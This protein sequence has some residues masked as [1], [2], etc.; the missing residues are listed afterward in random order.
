LP[1]R[2][3][4]PLG[5]LLLLLVPRFP[6]LKA[7]LP[8]LDGAGTA[9]AVPNK[10]CEPA[11]LEPELSDPNIEGLAAAEP[12]AA[13]VVPNGEAAAPPTFPKRPPPELGVELFWLDPNALPDVPKR[14]PLEAP[15]DAGAPKEKDMAKR[16]RDQGN[17]Q[18]W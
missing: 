1:N 13:G 17:R 9:L 15:L 12:P 8:P 3:E 16:C 10:V 6:K 11:G 14:P 4:V 18:A 7:V 2:G 5:V